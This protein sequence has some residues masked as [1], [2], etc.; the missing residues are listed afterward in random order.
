MG[1][2]HAPSWRAIRTKPI[3]EELPTTHPNGH[4]VQLGCPIDGHSK[5]C[6][7]PKHARIELR[8]EEWLCKLRSF[9]L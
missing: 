6:T 4:Q 5:S 1:A 9:P 3:K 7:R 2:Q 8:Q